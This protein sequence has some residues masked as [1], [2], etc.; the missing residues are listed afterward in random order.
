VVD[1]IHL[2]EGHPYAVAIS[3]NGSLLYVTSSWHGAVTAIATATNAPIT[4]FEVGNESYHVTF[5]PDGATAY[6]I[7]KTGDSNFRIAV[8][9]AATHRTSTILE[10]QASDMAVSPDGAYL[11]ATGRSEVWVFERT[12]HTLSATIPV[13]DAL[14]LGSRIAFTPDGKLA[15]RVGSASSGGGVV[16]AIDVA[17]RQVIGTIRLA[18]EA[19]AV[20]ITR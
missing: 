7:G 6:V 1:T 2:R 17:T 14:G 8:I 13:P 19:R 20:V 18:T 9:D 11:Y 15:F 4:E 10:Y 3:P 16:S 5:A 12:G